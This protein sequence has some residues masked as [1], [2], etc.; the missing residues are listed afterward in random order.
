VTPERLSAGDARLGTDERVPPPD[1]DDGP[2]PTTAQGD[3]LVAQMIAAA[4][5]AWRC[6]DAGEEIGTR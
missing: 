2:A 4:P 5:A 3:D 1:H 6:C